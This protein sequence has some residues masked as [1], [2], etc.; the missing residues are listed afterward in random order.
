MKGIFRIWVAVF[1]FFALCVMGQAQAEK[2][3]S[4]LYFVEEV[5]LKLDKSSD[6]DA[7]VK[8][9]VE[10]AK[11]HNYPHSWVAYSTNEMIYYFVYPIESGAEIAAIFSDWEEMTAKIGEEKWEALYERLLKPS[12]YYKYYEVEHLPLQS[13]TPGDAAITPMEAPATYWGFCYTK[14]G[15]ENSLVKIMTKYVD[16]YKGKNLPA[17]FDTYV[18]RTGAE[19]PVHFYVLRGKSFTDLFSKSDK[20]HIMAEAELATLWAEFTS[21]LRKYE[22]KLGMFRPDLS[23]MIEQQ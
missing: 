19:L 21:H 2:P 12:E 5:A 11:K 13:Y 3:K 17:G 18:V 14:P 23:Y 22:Y 4:Q 6:Y 7:A 1:V 10:L 8:E 20:V 15:H 9:V 16:L